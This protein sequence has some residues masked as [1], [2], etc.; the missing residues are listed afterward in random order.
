M[1]VAFDDALKKFFA[2]NFN[3]PLDKLDKC[4]RI[5]KVLNIEAHITERGE[6]DE[7][8]NVSRLVS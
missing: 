5:L 4:A 2:K 8:A 3:L 1:R 7:E 6:R